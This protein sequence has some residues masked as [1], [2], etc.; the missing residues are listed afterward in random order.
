[1]SWCRVG[2]HPQVEIGFRASSG[3]G[4][5]GGDGAQSAFILDFILPVPGSR[6]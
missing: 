5:A 3:L 2:D 1:M 6:W 4:Y